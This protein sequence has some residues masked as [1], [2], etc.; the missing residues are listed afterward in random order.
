ME[1]LVFCRLRIYWETSLLETSVGR[2]D[3]S[4]EAGFLTGASGLHFTRVIGAF[5]IMESTVKSNEEL[6]TTT[7]T[8]RWSL[9]RLS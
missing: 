8:G 5:A 4:R 2:R 1:T 7:F 9:L 6:R 3:S